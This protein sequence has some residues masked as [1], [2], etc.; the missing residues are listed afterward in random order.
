M[1]WRR[2]KHRRFL[3]AAV[4][5]GVLG[6]GA[7]VF[8]ASNTVPASNAGSGANSISGYTISAVS[9][10]L[11]TTNPQNVDQ[12]AFTISPAGAT[13]VKAQLVTGGTWYACVNSSGS[14]TCNTTVG[15]QATAATA[16]NLTV[17]ASQ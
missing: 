4:A 10:T 16:N 5:A 13:T 11:N 7:Y 3:A 6:L 17:V 9:Y 1:S 2:R 12:V 8:T 14:V 15:T